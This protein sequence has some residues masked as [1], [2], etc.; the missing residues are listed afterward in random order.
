MCGASR[1]LQSFQLPTMEVRLAHSGASAQGGFTLAVSRQ[2]AVATPPPCPNP[3][4]ALTIDL[5]VPP[6]RLY[7]DCGPSRGAASHPINRKGSI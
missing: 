1:V 7:S 3:A 5:N 4:K 2:P 6:R